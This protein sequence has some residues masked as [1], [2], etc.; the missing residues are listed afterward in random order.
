MYKHCIDDIKYISGNMNIN[1]LQYQQKYNL[2]ENNM[3]R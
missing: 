1:Y 3:M 2:I